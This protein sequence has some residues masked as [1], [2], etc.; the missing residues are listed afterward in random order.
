MEFGGLVDFL[1]VLCDSGWCGHDL[2]GFFLCLDLVLAVSL[3][4]LQ[5]GCKWGSPLDSALLSRLN[6]FIFSRRLHVK[7]LA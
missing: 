5:F 3:R 6:L 4:R 2:A 7:F 1:K